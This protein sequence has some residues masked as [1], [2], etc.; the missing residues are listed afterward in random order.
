MRLLPFDKF[1]IEIDKPKDIV[2]HL[3]CNN[4]DL[5][6]CIFEMPNAKKSFY[7]KVWYDKFRLMSDN[8]Y[9]KSLIVILGYLSEH[10]DNTKI[11]VTIRTHYSTIIVIMFLLVVCTLMS[12]FLLLNSIPFSIV[13]ILIFCLWYVMMYFIYKHETKK[14]KMK[15]SEI[16]N[17]NIAI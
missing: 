9:R 4:T 15:F 7:G 2:Y 8:R 5:N 12:I 13:P 1:T 6:K 10:G 17:A 14:V 3:L 16:F 11:D